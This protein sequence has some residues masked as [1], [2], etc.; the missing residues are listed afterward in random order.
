[1]EKVASRCRLSSENVLKILEF[2]RSSGNEELTSEILTNR[3]GV[4]LRTANKILSHLEEGG[5]AQIVG[6]KRLGMKGRPVNI[7]RICMEVK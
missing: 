5:A 1:M 4:S 2:S 7:Y 3:L 6:Q